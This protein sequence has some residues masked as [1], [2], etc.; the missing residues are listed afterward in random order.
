MPNLF[1][2]THRATLAA[3]LMLASATGA[4]VA[5]PYED[6]TAAYQRGDYATAYKL[7][8]PLAEKGN[9]TMQ[10][11]VGAMYAE[12]KG[13]PQDYAEALKWFRK[14]ADQGDAD[15]QGNLGFAAEQ[16]YGVPQNYAE[17]AK[18]YRLAAEQG[19]ARAQTNLGVMYARS[20]DNHTTSDARTR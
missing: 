14:A 20:S 10:T 1:P 4:T 18:W 8:L 7:T 5:G 6:A 17:A 13:V 12:G 16:G 11:N 2:R 15:A 9:A 3:S 19:D